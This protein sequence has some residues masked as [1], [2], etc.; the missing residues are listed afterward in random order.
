M[1]SLDE[2]RVLSFEKK[3]EVVT[4][5][6]SYLLHRQEGAHKIFLYEAGNFFVEVLYSVREHKV[7]GFNA[8]S[9]Q[10]WLDPYLEMISLEDLWA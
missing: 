9:H 8:F 6:A 7:A 2:F 10:R 4:F 5:G 1:L 3:C